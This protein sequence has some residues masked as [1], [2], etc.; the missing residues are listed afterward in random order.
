[1]WGNMTYF[2]ETYGCQ[3]NKAESASI[4]QLFIDRG[5]TQAENAETADFVIINTCSVRAKAETRIHG[6]LG[7]F[8]ALR[9]DRALLA[10]KIAEAEKEGLPTREISVRNVTSGVEVG[11]NPFTLAVTGCMAQDGQLQ[12]GWRQSYESVIM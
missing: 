2:F 3:M 9:K 10:D 7:W 8:S 1:M 5:W 4:E 11:P 12:D 6:R